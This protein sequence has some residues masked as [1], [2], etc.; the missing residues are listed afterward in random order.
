MV[1][2]DGIVPIVPTPF[3]AKGS[4]DEESLRRLV[5]YCVEG[6][7]AAIC[8]PAYGSEFY[9]LSE[10]ER[11]DV[12]RIAAEHAAGRVPVAGQA[13]HPSPRVAIDLGR[14]MQ[15]LGAAT[16]SM[17]A[18]RVFAL[19]EED[20]LRYFRAVCREIRVPLLIQDFN[21]G[22]PTVGAEFARRLHADCPNF[23]YL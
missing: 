15:D 23:R 3:D 2:I 5:E 12:V 10:Q 14:R 9:K 4:I 17:A 13:N 16:I 21:P 8:L 1:R 6:E 18:P 7:A 11:L 20:L 22:G 19:G